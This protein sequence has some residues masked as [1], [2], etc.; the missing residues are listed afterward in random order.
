MCNIKVKGIFKKKER[1]SKKSPAPIFSPKIGKN[2]LWAKL[3]NRVSLI[4]TSYTNCDYIRTAI[5]ACKKQHRKVFDFIHK[6]ILAHWC[7]Q[8]Y[9]SSICQKQ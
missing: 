2:K 4:F 5:A 9:P 3:R 1:I 8:G 7:K 6:S